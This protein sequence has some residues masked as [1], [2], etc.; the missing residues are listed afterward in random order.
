MKRIKGLLVEPYE[1]PKE[2]ELD[3]SLEAKKN[4]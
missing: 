1:L 3:N 2:I 4:I